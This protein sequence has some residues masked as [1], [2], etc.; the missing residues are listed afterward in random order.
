MKENKNKKKQGVLFR[1]CV[2]LLISTFMI[3]CSKNKDDVMNNVD[4]DN[5]SKENHQTDHEDSNLGDDTNQGENQDNNEGNHDNEDGNEQQDSSSSEGEDKSEV[6]TLDVYYGDSNGQYLLFKEVEVAEITPARII[7]ELASYDVLPSDVKVNRIEFLEEN[8]ESA[9]MID[10][11]SDFAESLYQMGTSG[12]WI[13]IGSVTNTFLSAYHVDKMMM[14]VDGEIVE[15]GHSVYDEYL[16]LFDASHHTTTS[17]EILIDGR[18][19]TVE[20]EIFFNPE[21]SFEIGYDTSLFEYT[22]D[23]D[24]NV[25][26][27]MA[28][29]PD[30]EVYPNVFLSVSTIDYNVEDTLEGLKL[31]SFTDQIVEIENV[32]VGTETATLLELRGGADPTDRIVMFYVL[33]HMDKTYL[34]EVDYYVEVET[35][36]LPRFEQMLSLFRF[37]E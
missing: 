33:E 36:Y 24:F 27:F 14:T 28:P 11:S 23:D 29:N 31:Q 9:M 17:D 10:F 20:L 21:L 6:T 25:A 13:M 35:E 19:E 37:V 4:N 7:E 5:A 22:Y 3:A 32:T 26:S 18:E 16:Y 8:G 34:I 30:I 15:S 1:L 12:E 2:L